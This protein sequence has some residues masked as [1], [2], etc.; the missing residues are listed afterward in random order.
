MVTTGAALL[1]TGIA[2]LVAIRAVH[3]CQVLEEQRAKGMPYTMI[4]AT[5]SGTSVYSHE[6]VTY[7]YVGEDAKVYADGYLL[8]E[9]A[10]NASVFL[11]N[12]TEI[13]IAD[14]V[15]INGISYN[16][17]RSL[18]VEKDGSVREYVS[19]GAP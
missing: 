4:S 10:G 7:I 9:V 19:I 1:V 8:A 2:L 16:G 6:P 5:R 17:E 12:Q 14:E 15:K 3:L 18:L 13:S 11:A